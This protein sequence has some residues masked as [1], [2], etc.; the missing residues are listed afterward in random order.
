VK[1]SGAVETA[2]A[3]LELA[4]IEGTIFDAAASTAGLGVAEAFA[5]RRLRGGEPLTMREVARRLG[6]E[7][8]HATAIVDALVRRGYLT[9]SVE[10][11]DRRVRVV[12]VTPAGAKKLAELVGHL[13][14]SD[15][16]VERLGHLERTN[17]R[18]LALRALVGAEGALAAGEG[19]S[20]PSQ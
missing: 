14:R 16:P 4:R 12:D 3:V 17:L 9:R 20:T 19:D 10:P 2:E 6:C 13:N 18:A 8:P 15:H 11:R 5:L 1:P 7:P